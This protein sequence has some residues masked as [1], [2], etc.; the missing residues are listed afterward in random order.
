MRSS[1][2]GLM[3]IR[4]SSSIPTTGQLGRDLGWR[5]GWA[6]PRRFARA[7]AFS[8][9]LPRWP[10]RVQELVGIKATKQ[11]HRLSPMFRELRT[12][13][14][15]FFRTAFRKAFCRFRATAKGQRRRSDWASQERRSEAGIRFLRSRPGVLAY[16]RDCLGIYCL[17]RSMSGARGHTFILAAPTI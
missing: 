10:R 9:I 8:M 14:I 12:F 6:T 1:M 11:S 7:T 5:T 3:E 13:R 16:R 17:T 4:G 15:H 2:W